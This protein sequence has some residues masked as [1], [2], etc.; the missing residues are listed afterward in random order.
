VGLQQVLHVAVQ[1]LI[2]AAPARQKVIPLL[3]RDLPDRFDE[4]LPSLV[5]LDI[6]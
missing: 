6:H 1:C 3:G 4:E 5:R 2:G